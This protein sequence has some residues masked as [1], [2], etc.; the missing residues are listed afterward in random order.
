M[1]HENIHVDLLWAQQTEKSQTA[2]TE[3]ARGRRLRTFRDGR[4]RAAHPT[5]CRRLSVR[6]WLEKGMITLKA[7]GKYEKITR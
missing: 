3:M 1:L 2:S 6:F 7:A 5:G 4:E